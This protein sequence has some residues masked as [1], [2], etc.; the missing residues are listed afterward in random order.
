MPR[1]TVFNT[2]SLDGRFVDAHGDMSWAHVG[3]DDPEVASFT[4]RNAMGGG[5][6]VFGR[7]TYELMAGYWPTPAAAEAYPTVAKQMNAMEKIVFSHT[8]NSADWNNTTLLSGDPAE[9]IGRIKSGPGPD[10]TILGSG[11]IVAQLAAAELIDQYDVVIHPIALGGGRTMFDGLPQAQPL[12]L[13]DSRVFKNGK[14]FLSYRPG[15]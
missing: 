11:T 10:L 8:L 3:G 14:V 5:A 4:A 12:T 2:I 9:E 15:E 13:V 6:L 1:L 7:V